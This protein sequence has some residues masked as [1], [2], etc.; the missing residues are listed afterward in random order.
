[1]T[2]TFALIIGIDRSDTRL[3]IATLDPVT[4]SATAHTVSTDPAAM[5][6]WF[7]HQRQSLPAQ[8]RIGVA[9]EEPATNLIVFFSQFEGVSLY[10]LNPA[11]VRS[12]CK[13][14]AISGAHTDTTDAAMI[15]RYLAHYYTQLRPRPQRSAD[16]EELQRLNI[17]RRDLVD[18]RTALVNR[19]QATL[20]LYF[21]QAIA[22]LSE[23]LYRPMDC[24]FLLRWSSLQV[25]QK[26]KSATLS[27]FWQRHGSRSQEIIAKR[28]K[29]ISSAVA[30]TAAR[31][32][33]DPL[34]MEV[35]VMA[36]QLLLLDE[37]IKRFEA[38]IAEVARRFE[39]FDFFQ[40]LP[41]AGPVFAAR[42]L[43]VFGQD[44]DLWGTAEDVLRLSGVAPVTQQSGGK[45]VVQRRRKAPVF[46]HQTFVEWAGQSWKQ[47]AW[48]KAF[49]HY[50]KERGKTYHGIMRLLA[51]KWIRI[52]FRAWKNRV[53]YDEERYIQSLIKNNS[54]ICEHL[55]A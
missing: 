24:Q 55:G 3:D 29:T 9:F 39:D 52:V 21:P 42:L 30:L 53:A 26:A 19:L 31:H 4:Q 8:A 34:A 50:H 37:S 17:A 11:A 2:H 43:A 41:G 23:D 44:R 20:K 25:L 27:A 46:L 40:K 48:A 1:M 16:L 14:F 5:R 18:E 35:E 51:N 49:Y 7:E 54:P 45:R 32:L 15:A 6:Q 38:R 13:S 28:L 10:P 33:I 22:L 47:S 36:R 12:Y